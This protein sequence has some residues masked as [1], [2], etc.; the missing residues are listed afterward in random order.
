VREHQRDGPGGE[1][2][3]QLGRAHAGDRHLEHAASVGGEIG[4]RGNQEEGGH[5][6]RS[7]HRRHISGCR[8]AREQQRRARQINN[9]IDVIAVARA[10]LIAHAR[11]GA[12]EAV[13]E[14]V[15]EQAQHHKYR[16]CNR[17]RLRHPERQPG[18]GHRRQPKRR[19][20]I[21]IDLARQS[22]GDPDQR[23]FFGGGKDAVVLANVSG[24]GHVLLLAT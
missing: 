10:L 6:E 13:A 8:Q 23:A 1:Q 5:H 4:F 14:P 22:L 15:E 3:P 11:H 19:K 21:G 17:I 9:V 7:D 16:A 2:N 18:A 20:V 12:V 24:G